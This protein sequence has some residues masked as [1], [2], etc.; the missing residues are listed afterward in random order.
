MVSISVS[1]NHGKETINEKSV[2]RITTASLNQ[3]KK[4]CKSLH[5]STRII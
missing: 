4:L 5:F 2:H 1:V 3:G